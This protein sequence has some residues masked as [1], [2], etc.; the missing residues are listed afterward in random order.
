MSAA[1]GRDPEPGGGRIVVAIDDAAAGESVLEP[2]SLLARLLRREL[3]VVYVESAVS[4]L[5]AALPFAQVLTRSTGAWQPFAPADVEQ[6]FRAQAAR[7]RQLAERAALRHAVD[8]SLR[9]MRGSLDE[10]RERLAGESDLLFVGRAPPAQ[11]PAPAIRRRRTVV[12]VLDEP[13]EA[14]E[15]AHRVAARLAEAWNGVVQPI[16]LEP[17]APG[18]GIAQWLGRGP[19]PDVLVM[20]RAA[21]RPGLRLALPCP[22]LL[23]D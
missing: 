16:R 3:A 7:L 8:W 10:A 13:G 4:L 2:S 6:A 17:P 23:V 12:A 19:V 20:P 18:P 21:M 1:T 5:A 15:R 14:G 22:V 11:A 9:V